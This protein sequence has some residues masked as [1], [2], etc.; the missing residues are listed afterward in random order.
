MWSHERFLGSGQAGLGHLGVLPGEVGAGRRNS[1]RSGNSTAVLLPN[2][3]L[4]VVEVTFEADA[5]KASDDVV[6]RFDLDLPTSSA[7]RKSH[8]YIQVKWHVHHG[9]PFGYEDFTKPDFINATTTSLLQRL[10]AARNATSPLACFTFLTTDRLSEADPLRLMISSNDRHLLLERLFD[11]SGDRSKAGKVGRCWRMHLKLS[12]DDELRAVL[13]GFRILEGQSSSDELREEIGRRATSCGMSIPSAAYSDFRFDELA[14]Q[15]KK[16]RFSGLTK[17]TFLA[18]CG[19]EGIQVIL[20]TAH[21]GLTL[22]IRSFLR[23]PADAAGVHPDNTLL[24]N[25]YFRKR[26][27]MDG[28]EW[29]RDIR[30]LVEAFLDAKLAGVPSVR[31]VLDAHLSLLFLAGSI[32]HHK[33]SIDVEIVQNSRTGTN[34]WS[35]KDK[36]S[37]PRFAVPMSE[38]VCSGRHLA[39]GI[40]ISQNVTAAMCAYVTQNLPDV[41]T[42]ISF[43]FPDGSGQ[44]TVLGG[45][46]ACDLADQVA[47]HIRS[48]RGTSGDQILHIFPA[49]PGAFVFYLEQLHQSIAPCIIYEF[50][51]DR[52]GN[53]TYHPS[54]LIE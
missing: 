44:R 53:R 33:R 42:I 28:V 50:D 35:E 32:I 17:D 29:Q 22:A 43:E 30:P 1:S 5:P 34:F 27:L 8:E 47:Q 4:C 51:F 25:D 11:G 13:G 52:E 16:R 2:P 9:G 49:T 54:I 39:V 26:Y 23:A 7:T 18:F 20:P 24:L 41:G 21:Y 31:L 12:S 37:G 19:E 38:T 14:R 6:L 3:T 40:S 46:H 45:T 15:L 10:Q 36:I 48:L